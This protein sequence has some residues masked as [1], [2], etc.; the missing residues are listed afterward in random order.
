MTCPLMRPASWNPPMVTCHAEGMVVK[1]EWTVPRSRIQVNLNGDWEPIMKASQ[2]CL[3]SIVEHPEGVVISVNYAPCL[4]ERDGLYSFELA[5]DGEM[6]ITCPALQPAPYVFPQNGSTLQPR[7]Q[8]FQAPDQSQ[9]AE[10]FSASQSTDMYPQPRMLPPGISINQQVTSSTEHQ[11]STDTTVTQTTHDG[12][13]LQNPQLGS[14][15]LPPL[16]CPPLCLPELPNCCL[17]IAFHQHLHHI[18]P[19]G[20]GSN[21]APLFYLGQAFLPS[22]ALSG[23]GSG[24]ALTPEKTTAKSKIIQ[25]TT[26]SPPAFVSPEPLPPVNEG[27]TYLQPQDGSPVTAQNGNPSKA[28]N[29]NEPI[30]SPHLQWPH[31][32]QSEALHPLAHY[33]APFRTENQNSHLSAGNTDDSSRPNFMPFIGQYSQEQQNKLP[34]TER[35][36]DKKHTKHKGLTHDG[37]SRELHRWNKDEKQR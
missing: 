18:V 11:A 20:L 24:H 14:P 21:N 27:Q 30:S 3:F 19:V 32:P 4:K 25:L 22:S 7:P 16:N 29:L 17:K 28:A 33:N 9:T 13:V 35:S 1:T 10:M 8:S 15:I 23:D 12:A 2:R 5:G 34:V 36:F 26:T 6:K 37:R 31:F